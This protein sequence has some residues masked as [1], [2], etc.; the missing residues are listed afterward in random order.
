[1]KTPPPCPLPFDL[2]LRDPRWTAMEA[3]GRGIIVSL[4]LTCWRDGWIS[5]DPIVAARVAGL[6]PQLV[7]QWWPVL[8]PWLSPH[9]TEDGALVLS[10]LIEGFIK[11]EKRHAAAL[12]AVDC[13]MTRPRKKKGDDTSPIIATITDDSSRGSGP[14]DKQQ[15]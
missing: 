11:R 13:R 5:A 9:E 14:L 2:L 8:R 3:A 7:R 1:M 4:A 12:H 10:M 6:D 15:G